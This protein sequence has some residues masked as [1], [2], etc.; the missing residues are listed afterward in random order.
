[1][2]SESSTG[3]G[4]G[5]A[6]AKDRVRKA[7]VPEWVSEIGF[8][9]QF[10]SEGVAPITYLLLDNQ[11][12]AE[13]R[14][15]FVRQVVRLETMEAVQHWSQWRL[16]FE[17]K[18]QLI[19]VH[20]L[21]TRR[22]ETET[23]HLDLGKAHFLQREEGL[24]RFVI[25]GWFTCLIIL[26]DV[27][28][29]DVIEYSY[30]IENHPRLL[31]EY[32]SFFFGLP[33]G[34]SVG[35]YHFGIRFNPARQMKWKTSSGVPPPVETKRSECQVSGVSQ[36]SECQV[37]GIRCQVQG[38]EVKDK[39]NDGVE[40]TQ[41]DW[42]GE[43]YVGVKPEVNTPFWHI[44]Y[45]WMNISD[46]PDWQT[47]GTAVAGHWAMENGEAAIAEL[48]KEIESNE[49]ELSGRIEKA[50]RLV[51]D[52]CRYFSVN[53]ELGGYVPASPEIVA[54]RR[55]GDCKDLSFLLANLL[56]KLGV[57][58]RPILVNAFLRKTVSDLLPAVS[59]FNHAVVEFEVD[60]KKRWI[61]TTLKD[62]GGG[63]Y[64]RVIGDFG[65]GLPVDANGTGLVPRP[66]MADQSNLFELKENILLGTNGAPALLA[67]TLRSEGQQAEI[68]REQ[69]RKAGA[70]EM[71][72]QRLQ[73][74]ANRFSS[75]KR[76]GQLQHRD[77]R[78]ANQFVLT[79]TFEIP[80]HL[81]TLPNSNLCQFQL[82]SHWIR[83]VLPMP[84]AA[85]RR[86]PFA[87]PYPCQIT[88]VAEVESPAIQRMT[89]Q[90]PQS[91]VR[92]EFIQFTRSDR[93]G[94]GYYVSSFSLTTSA[95]CVPAD[96][97]EGHRQIVDR[98]WRSAGRQLSIARGFA[99]PVQP[100]GFGELPREEPAGAPKPFKPLLAPQHRGSDEGHSHKHRRRHH[101]SH[102]SRS[103][104]PIPWWLVRLAVVGAILI[105]SAIAR[106]CGKY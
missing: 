88:Y 102:R 79:E 53:L 71:A 30:T 14:E 82:P 16:Q 59:L 75:A 47:I 50:I 2:L 42:A 56:K 65:V 43:K 4:E 72:K 77:D 11:L 97:I 52:E 105:L 35:K 58:A 33:L 90:D 98:I 61:D 5:I 92:D 93:A 26:E 104:E 64:N 17:P 38:P 34:L 84:E 23:D 91:Q 25:H 96:K 100:R 24:E 37:S 73:V 78:A 12:H 39:V 94:K 95:P 80:P 85:A 49:P 57:Q 55:F 18:T 83:G 103:E 27:R 1:M 60:G 46:F 99:R 81:T 19:T 15:S 13:R 36:E 51:Q 20:S 89:V 67:V 74:I 45:P 8:D 106:S 54:R 101:S 22:G 63:P 86:T 70:E 40:I 69:L 7:P 48:A 44:G 3:A 29:G 66:E 68:L 21:K 41:W 87:L 28:P 6:T 31:P 10:K 62:Q 76:V 32:G 9:P